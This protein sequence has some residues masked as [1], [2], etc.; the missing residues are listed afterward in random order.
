[1]ASSGSWLPVIDLSRISPQLAAQSGDVDLVVLEGMGRA[2][3]T[4]LY[5]QLRWGAF[6]C[7]ICHR[8]AWCLLRKC[9]AL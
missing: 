2:I 1:M 9:A 7:H 8:V 5:A 6:W 3:E 4:N